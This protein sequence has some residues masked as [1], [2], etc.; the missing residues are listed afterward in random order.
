[1]KSYRTRILATLA[2]VAAL[3]AAVPALAADDAAAG[4]WQVHKYTLNFMG[5]TT[6]YS[7]DGLEDRV[8]DLLVW[9]GARKDVKSASFGCTRGYG[10][11]SKFATTEVTFYT[12]APAAPGDAG[13]MPAS[14]RKVD[15]TAH[16]PLQLGEGDCELVE[17]FRDQLLPLFTTRNVKN[18]THCEPHEVNPGD[19]NLS[20]E[21][22]V[23]SSPAATPAQSP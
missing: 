19:L 13:A 23:P 9:A 14:W 4:V 16:R 5:F 7:C 18:A 12:L 22:L 3:G 21:A 6:T 20:F 8:R 17:Q 10:S 1:M 11:P 2:A 15:W